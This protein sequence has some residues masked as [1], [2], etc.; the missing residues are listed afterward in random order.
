MLSLAALVALETF[1][2]R[3]GQTIERDSR[4]FLAADYR[5]QAWRPFDDQVLPAL[6]EEQ[7]RGDVAFRTD[8][9]AA[10]E[11]PNGESVTGNVAAI[12]GDYPFYGPWRTE[13]EGLTV[14]KLAA[15][16][17][18]LADASLR[19]KD[20]K[21]GDRVRLGKLTLRFAGYLLEEPQTVASAFSTGPRLVIHRKFA[22]GTGLL[23]PGARAFRQLLV[24][25]PLPTE[26]FRAKIRAKAPD[27]HLRIITPERA[28]RQA[29]NMLERMRGFLSLVLLS[30]LFLS[31]AGIFMMFRSRYLAQLPEFL[32]LR[33]LGMRSRQI[34][35]A[36]LRESLG[37]AI[38]GWVPGAALGAL[39]ERMIAGYA[40]TR[41]DIAL[42]DA[43]PLLPALLALLVALGLVGLATIL[44]LREILRVPVQAAFR[45]SDARTEGLSV[46]DAFYA[47]LAAVA[48]T[49]AVARSFQLG[50]SFLGG[51]GGAS[52]GLALVAWLLSRGLTA[53]PLRSRFAWRQAAL[54]FARQPGPSLLLVLT[55]GL[56]LYFLGLVL[57][58]GNSLRR[59][60][61][62][63]GRM[64]VPNLFLI[65]VT[66]N[67]RDGI[68]KL[69][70]NVSFVPVVQA[71][72]TE[73]RGEAVQEVTDRVEGEHDAEQFYRTRE[74]FVT[75]RTSLAEGERVL[76]GNYGTD[77]FG[78]A[79]EGVVRASLEAK[80]A[81]S[82][83][84]AVGDR[85][86]FEIGGVALEAEVRSYRKVDWFNLRPNFFI[87]FHEDDLQG[88][89]FGY[90]GLYRA[91]PERLVETQRE[92]SRRFPAVTAM[93]GDSIAR[94]LLKILDQISLSVFS[95]SLF[96]GGS[97]LF[98]FAGMLI[99]RRQQK[100]RE[101]S[102]LKC[103]GAPS[104]LLHRLLLAESLV[105]GF[106]ASL[107][108]F[109]C[110]WATAAVV[111]RFVLDIPL[112]VPGASLAGGLLGLWPLIAAAGGWVLSKGLLAQSASGLFRAAEEV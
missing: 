24:R 40:R 39:A 63:S 56:C 54:S 83:G 69:L 38:A 16:P 2:R 95:V 41:L 80:F 4:N 70:S 109:V 59:Q 72:I 84:L 43:S 13:P 76:R 50:F 85:F 25:T 44:P 1:S 97:C 47:G 12:E 29:S 49:L 3:I 57:L 89:P 8:F 71:R 65:G 103:L 30:G 31:G 106:V 23:G 100:L 14:A 6:E 7:S 66:E 96:T 48:L 53:L 108:A 67:D 74:Y 20:L 60:V 52:L 35:S 58:L 86:R 88:A 102:L 87:A 34:L 79:I 18:L 110:A 99:S 45:Q 104:A 17:S 10:I 37:V 9:L 62:F 26:V 112:E 111:C 51:L 78:P 94:R 68:T 11:L 28:N 82:I 61:D 90:V 98:V 101:L 73:I 91:A 92:V 55:T 21:V 81:D 19:A 15:E 5:I 93:D 107:T 77:P 22:A 36:A 105:A 27:P 33:C 42:A 75:R 46:R 64:G 32:T